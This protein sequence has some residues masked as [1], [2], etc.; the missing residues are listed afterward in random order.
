[1]DFIFM[2][3]RNDRTIEDAAYLVD[4]ACDLGVRH[5][6]FKDVGVPFATMQEL[7]STIR[8]RGGVCY[9]EVVS[10]TPRPCSGR[11][12]RDVRS[13][14]T[15]SSA[16]PISTRRSASSATSH[17]IFRFPATR[18]GIRPGWEAR[19]RSSP[20]IAAARA[21]WGAAAWICSPTGRPRPTRSTWSGRR[22]KRCRRD[23]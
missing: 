14:S 10:T 6:G 17:A 22:A 2:L 18:S 13:M 11:S 5:I 21:P 7:A 8:R 9:L 12:K 16:A 4:S 1:M 3:T 20:T 23:S 15:A 19:R